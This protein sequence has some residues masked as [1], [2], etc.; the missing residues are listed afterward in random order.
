ML[1]QKEKDKTRGTGMQI[2]P[3][4]IYKLYTLTPAWQQIFSSDFRTNRMHVFCFSTL[5]TCY[6]FGIHYACSTVFHAVI[7]FST[8]LAR[9]Q[10]NISS[11]NIKQN[12]Y[13]MQ[14]ILNVPIRFQMYRISPCYTVLS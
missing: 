12:T 11:L 9:D 13:E 5:S 14:S 7:S 2:I 10:E 3:P 6:S 8:L 4:S 1:S